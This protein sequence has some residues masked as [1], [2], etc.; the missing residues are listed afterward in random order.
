MH[1]TGRRTEHPDDASSERS[2]RKPVALSLSA[3]RGISGSPVF[4][5]C[6]LRPGLVLSFSTPT[7]T[8]P[9]KGFFDMDDAPVQFGFTYAGQNK[10]T[11]SGGELR[12][13]VHETKA[14]SN[15]IFYLPK[16]HGT[17]EQPA[18]NPTCIMGVIASPLLLASY[19]EESM[20]QLPSAFRKN[21]EGVKGKPMAWFGTYT[22]EKHSLLTQ[23]LNCPYSGGLRKLYLDGRV[24]EL[25][26]LQIGDY[27]ESETSRCPRTRPLCPDDIERIRYARDVLVSDLENPPSLPELAARVGINEK[28]LKR[29]FRQVFNNSVFGYFREYRIHKAYEIL[30]EGNLNVTE[31][32]YAVGYQSLSHFSQAFK[33]RFGILPK[34]FLTSTRRRASTW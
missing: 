11:Y 29:G 20:D 22:P 1:S 31:A 17:I 5:S 6:Q 19:F 24:M 8:T 14:G 9:L 10:C 33:D 4:E 30:Q 18:E 7:A 32:A 12:N 34:A 16:T 13:Q 28:K 3:D 26:T 21:L 2:N 23:I 15:G 25:L 27:I